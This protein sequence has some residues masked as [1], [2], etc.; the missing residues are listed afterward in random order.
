MEQPQSR[1]QKVEVR[2]QNTRPNGARIPPSDSL[3]SRPALPGPRLLFLLLFGDDHLGAAED[4]LGLL[5]GV[6][7]LLLLG[8]EE[9]PH[10]LDAGTAD[11]L[12]Q[13]RVVGGTD[14]RV[15]R[16]DAVT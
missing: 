9:R 14:D 3:A 4:E 7:A 1:N 5:A 11:A 10:A 12:V 15:V 13:G 16:V 8:D 6:A 2:S